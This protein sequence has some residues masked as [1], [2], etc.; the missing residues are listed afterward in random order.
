MVV[1]PEGDHV[2]L[3]ELRD[4]LVTGGRDHRLADPA[5]VVRLLRH[6]YASVVVDLSHLDAAEQAGY[7]AAYLARSKPNGPP[8]AC[9]NGWSSTKPTTRFGRAGTRAGRVQPRRQ[10]LPARHLA[11][12]RSCR[13]DA[14]AALDAVIALGSPRPSDHLVDLT[15]AVADMPR[16]E[17]ARLLDGPSG[18]RRPGLAGAP[19][20]RRSRS[21]SGRRS[22]PHLR[23]EH[24]YDHAGVEPAHRFYFR[25]EADTPTGAI[26]ANLSELRS[27]ARPLRP[28]TCCAT[29]APTTT[30][31]AGSPASSTTSRSPPSS[32]PPKP[33]S[34]TTAPPRSSNRHASR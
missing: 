31:P 11:A 22:T 10:G 18:P 7:A 8:P 33:N 4:V 19:P 32:P 16:A 15:A 1:D 26:A 21:R 20:T 2:G 6:R 9:P 14:L 5:E 13:R 29:T 34:P 30:S 25:A 24:K 17:I 3:G 28:R 12:R 23:H 27:R